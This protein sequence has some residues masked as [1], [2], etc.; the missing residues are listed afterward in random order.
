VFG[1]DNRFVA[2]GRGDDEGNRVGGGGGERIGDHA[3]EW[4]AE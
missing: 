4:A 3:N 1:E 2:E